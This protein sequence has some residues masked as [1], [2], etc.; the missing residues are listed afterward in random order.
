M[1]A[2][3]SHESGSE[4]PDTGWIHP[5]VVRPRGTQ[6]GNALDAA[7]QLA[8]N[9]LPT[10]VLPDGFNWLGVFYLTGGTQ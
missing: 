9:P 3:A 2:Q 4:A 5:P 10:S 7:L 1:A 8:A 6:I